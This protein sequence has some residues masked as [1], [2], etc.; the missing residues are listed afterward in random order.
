MKQVHKDIPRAK[1]IHTDYGDVEYIIVDGTKLEKTMFGQ[2]VYCKDNVRPIF[3]ARREFYDQV[4]EKLDENYL[5]KY[6]NV[7]A[8]LSSRMIP[9]SRMFIATLFIVIAA[10][11]L[12][13]ITTAL[14]I[15]TNFTR[16]G[17]WA[18]FILLLIVMIIVVKKMKQFGE[19]SKAELHSVTTY[20]ELVVVIDNIDTQ[21]ELTNNATYKIFKKE[22]QI[23]ALRA[24]QEILRKVLLTK[25]KPLEF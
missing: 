24:E 21:I 5:K 25:E 2:Y 16:Y 22:K 18:T 13:M 9:Y 7:I 6:A 14:S 20:D 3:Y 1:I 10:A 8:K 23:A 15:E 4:I 11:V 12:N 17:L 19:E